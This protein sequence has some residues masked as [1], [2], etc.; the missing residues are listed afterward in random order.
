MSFIKQFLDLQKQKKALRQDVE[1]KRNVITC[2]LY[3]G[4][5]LDKFC[6]KHIPVINF[7]S[8]DT[9]ME[10]KI[11]HCEF[12][13]DGG[14]C[15]NQSCRLWPK[16]NAYNDAKELYDSVKSAQWNLVKGVFKFRKK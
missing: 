5:E 16:N 10:I 11:D 3:D 1:Q 7:A 6:I 14:C 2:T 13:C 12:F 8:S 4:I 15:Q 9:S